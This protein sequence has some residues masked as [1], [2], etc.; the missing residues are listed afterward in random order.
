MPSVFISE[1][2]SVHLVSQP[3]SNWRSHFCP[4]GLVV[5]VLKNHVISKVK[6]NGAVLGFPQFLNLASLGPWEPLPPPKPT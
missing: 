4:N 2:S 6:V 3:V 5:P 1:S